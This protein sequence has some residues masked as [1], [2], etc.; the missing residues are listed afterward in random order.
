MTPA[1]PPRTRKLAAHLRRQVA[2]AF[3]RGTAPFATLIGFLLLNGCSPSDEPGPD[4]AAVRT[5]IRLQTDWYPQPEHGGFYQAL[6]QGYYAEAGLDVKIL[7]GG[8]GARTAQKIVAGTA[9]VGLHRS[10]DLIMLAAEQLP[11]VMVAA[12]MQHDP[13]A[14]LLHATNPIDSFAGLDGQTIMAMPG[15]NWTRYL[16]ARYQIDFQLVP[17]SFS[18]A[19]F[20]SD[21]GF[22][23]QCFITSEPYF[24]RE[25]GVEPK[26]LLIADWGY[27]PYRVIFTTHRFA[28]EHP[29]A[30]R[31]FV[32]TSIRGW[33]EFIRGD[34]SPAKRMIAERNEHMTDAFMEFSIATMRR[35]ELVTGD[36]ERGGQIGLMTRERLQAQRDLLVRLDVLE[37]PLPLDRFARFDFLPPDLRAA[38]GGEREPEPPP[39]QP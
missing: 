33:G 19:R 34:P 4:G 18:L 30:L 16:K 32:A 36:P 23:Q 29:E 7:A 3:R 39:H 20:L 38:A 1:A 24:A 15:T 11:F 26:T 17:M 9:D 21:P 6:A 13:Q 35:H 5:L 31:A 22:I 12:F 27:D 14:I 2:T 37:E 25:N 28:R 8:P 10:D